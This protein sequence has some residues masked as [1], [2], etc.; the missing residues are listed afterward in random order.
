MK[1]TS[2]YFKVIFRHTGRAEEHHRKHHSPQSESGICNKNTGDKIF[3]EASVENP[4]GKRV[5]LKCIKKLS[6]N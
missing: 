5:I 1:A 6:V 4:V 2:V 3:G